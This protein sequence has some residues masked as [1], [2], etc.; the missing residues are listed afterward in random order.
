MLLVIDAGNTHTVFGLWDGADWGAIWR[1]RTDAG[2]TEDQIADFYLSLC[3]ES[4]IEPKPEA[5]FC[6]NVVPA[7]TQALNLFATRWLDKEIQFLEANSAGIPV[8][9]DPP[10]AVGADRLANAVA[11]KALHSTPAIV[12]DFGTATTFDVVGLEGEYVGGSILPGPI[13][14]MEALFSRAAKLPNV[15]IAAPK[16]AIGRDTRG[17]LQSGLV[18]GY[19]GAI[20]FL[21]K[22]IK[23]ELSE[24]AI[25][26]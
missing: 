7:L 22:K 5:V 14:A 17:S 4:S 11:A 20:D 16:E 2:A 21:A 19:V 3:R 26:I 15:D 6:A 8:L 13:V 24:K 18:Y 1:Y 10:S 9:Y 25:V 23:A 12:V